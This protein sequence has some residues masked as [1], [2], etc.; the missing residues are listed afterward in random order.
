MN[1]NDYETSLE[2]SNSAESGETEKEE[3]NECFT[4]DM[5]RVVLFDWTDL[6]ASLGKGKGSPV[7]VRT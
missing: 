5:R 1:A 6:I 4:I 3:R 7:Y 2:S